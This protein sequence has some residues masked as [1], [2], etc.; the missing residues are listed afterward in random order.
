[1]KDPVDKQKDRI[2]LKKLTK[3]YLNR[4]TDD[5]GLNWDKGKKVTVTDIMNTEY[6]SHGRK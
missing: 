6:L 4:N 1:M 5:D 2:Q 3:I